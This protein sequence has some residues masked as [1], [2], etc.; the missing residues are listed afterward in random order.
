[1][2]KL[3]AEVH[4]TDFESCIFY[5]FLYFAYINF[6]WEKLG[7]SRITFFSGKDYHITIENN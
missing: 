1:M 5:T 6:G 3:I 7:E 4:E 2:L